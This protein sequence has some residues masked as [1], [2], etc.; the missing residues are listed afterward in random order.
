MN[1][2]RRG[3]RV[4]RVHSNDRGVELTRDRGSRHQAG[5]LRNFSFAGEVLARKVGG[6]NGEERDASVTRATPSSRFH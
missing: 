2:E 5:E 6:R 3:R 1:A 4:I